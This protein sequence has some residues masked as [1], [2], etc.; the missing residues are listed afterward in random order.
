MGCGVLQKSGRQFLGDTQFYEEQYE[1]YYERPGVMHFDSA[2]YSIMADWMAAALGSFTPRNILDVGCGTG[3]SMAAIHAVY[4]DAAIEGIEPSVGNAEKAIQAGFRV[5][6]TRLNAS[7]TLSNNYDLIYANNV[8]QHV[9]DPIEFLSDVAARLAPTGRAAFVLPDAAEPCKEM[10]W[11]DHNFSFRPSDIA[12]MAKLVGL[13]MTGWLT[14]PPHHTLRNKQL[15][16]LQ[17]PKG[18][19]SEFVLQPDLY[20][21]DVLLDRRTAYMRK[22][23]AMDDLLVKRTAGFDRVFN[24]GASMWTWLIAG[25]CPK[26][27]S[28]VQTCL[29]DGEKGK[30]V[31]KQVIPTADANLDG[32]SAIVLGINPENQ[33]AFADRLK[34]RGAQLITWS[35]WITL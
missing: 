32:K 15:T 28:K 31:G 22:W 20:S 21:L 34:G 24:F 12:R 33:T 25:Y 11:C 5:H 3:R 35:D 9:V 4:P 30:C 16:I 29:V 8:L 2:R 18:R 19:N 14:N 23:E 10:M 7:Q 13:Q 26:Y 27:W 6:S 17:R 1:Q